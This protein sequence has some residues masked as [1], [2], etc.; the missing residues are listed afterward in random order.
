MTAR[1]QDNMDR[2]D[3]EKKGVVASSAVFTPPSQDEEAFLKSLEQTSG[4]YD[5]KVTVG[6]PRNF[7]A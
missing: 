1:K 4:N 6:G 7:A 3:S 5:P 2:R